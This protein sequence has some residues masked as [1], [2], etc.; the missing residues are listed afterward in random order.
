MRDGSDLARVEVLTGDGG[1]GD[2]SE[3][4]TWEP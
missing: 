2:F 3:K 1:L 4:V